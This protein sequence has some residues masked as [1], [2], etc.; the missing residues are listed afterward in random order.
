ME[1]DDTPS[2]TRPNTTFL[3]RMLTGVTRGNQRVLDTNASKAAEKVR[4]DGSCHRP[5]TSPPEM[6][7]CP[8]LPVIRLMVACYLQLLQ[9]KKSTRKS[10]RCA[11]MP[12]AWDACWPISTIHTQCN[13]TC[14]MSDIRGHQGHPTSPFHMNTGCWCIRSCQSET[15]AAE[16]W[17]AWCCCC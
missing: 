17:Q 6:H 3:S 12:G 1:D 9:Q 13:T 5:S 14:I 10:A 8:S 16:S 7:C 15:C 4:E 2:R 11:S